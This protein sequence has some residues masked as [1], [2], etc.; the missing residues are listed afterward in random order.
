MKKLWPALLIVFLIV[1]IPIS[2]G[3]ERSLTFSTPL[4]IRYGWQW[5]AGLVFGAILFLAA[6][7]RPL[8]FKPNA[9]Y[10]I[11]AVVIATIV[12]LPYVILSIRYVISSDIEMIFLQ[13]AFGFMLCKGLFSPA[14]AE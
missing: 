6:N 14:D 9:F 5:L 11:C 1:F 3:I 10:L 7:E 13:T 12:V 2:N 8:K 4:Y